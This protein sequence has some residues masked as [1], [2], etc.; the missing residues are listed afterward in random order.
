MQARIRRVFL[1]M[2]LRAN[3]LGLGEVAIRYRIDPRKLNPGDMIVFVNRARTLSKIL[4]HNQTLLYLRAD[5]KINLETFEHLAQIF[6]KTGNLSVSYDQAN[7][8]I[9]KKRIKRGQ[10]KIEEYLA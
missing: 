1:G 9:L 8:M 10:V 5:S 3:H 7:A 6:S 2:D 4:C